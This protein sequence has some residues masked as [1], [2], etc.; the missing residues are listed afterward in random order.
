MHRSCL[1]F[2]ICKVGFLVGNFWE[3]LKTIHGTNEHKFFSQIP[4]TS[5][6]VGHTREIFSC[7]PIYL[8]FLNYY[9]LWQERG[10][11]APLN[12]PR[13]FDIITFCRQHVPWAQI[14]LSKV[15]ELSLMRKRV[16]FPH[17]S[18][19]FPTPW[20]FIDEDW[21]TQLGVMGGRR[22]QALLC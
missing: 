18:L 12:F 2:Q 10:P 21:H 11:F 7:P 16:L 13:F 20:A 4:T 9:K 6:F 19:E 8:G 17:V 3:L 14:L 22:L 15:W 1:C 5:H